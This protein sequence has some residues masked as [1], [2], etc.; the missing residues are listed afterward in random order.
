MKKKYIVFGLL[1][2]SLYSFGQKADSIYSKKKLSKTDI[3]IVYSHY[4]QNG[5]HSAVT[6]GTGTEKLKVF[7]PDITINRQ[8]DTLTRYSINLGV[9]I[10]TSASTDKIDFVVSSASLHDK[11]GYL[12]FSYNKGVRQSGLTLGGSAHFSIESDYTSLGLGL[13]ANHLSKDKSR[14]WSVSLESFL[15]DLRWGRLSGVRPLELVYPSELRNREWNDEYLRR[16]Y[17]LSLGVQQTIN[18]RLLLGIFP[19]LVYQRGLLATPFH[20]VYFKDDSLRVEN[21]PISR[22]KI[23]VGIQLNAFIGSRCILKSYYRFYWDDWKIIAHTLQLETAIKVSP[24]F[25]ITPLLRLFTQS[26]SFYFKPYKEHLSLERYYSS[27]YDLSAIKSLETGFEIRHVPMGKKP[28]RS[29][30]SSNELGIRYAF[31]KRSDGLYAHIITLLID[32]RM[33]KKPIQIS[34]TIS[35]L[36]KASRPTGR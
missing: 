11:H 27:D 35:E 28:G 22:I 1:A 7:S 34:N 9:D 18:K 23:P 10:I 12:S 13:N 2:S 26:G 33:A 17:N 15:D 6:G 14:E 30:L 24:F 21:L 19:G 32:L 31:Y 29:A 20:R 36:N 3:Q 25:T 16:S 4:I 5:N 8:V